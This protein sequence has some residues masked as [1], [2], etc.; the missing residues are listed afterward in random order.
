[1]NGLEL[2]VLIGAIILL[3]GWLAGRLRISAPLVLLGLG[4]ILGF[5][6]VLGDVELPPDLVLLLFLPALLYW[7]SLNTSAREIRRNLRVI[8][9]NAVPLVLVTA[10]V[11]ALIGH[12]FGLPWSV[13]IALGAVV[14]PTDATAVAAVVRHMPRRTL[15]ILRT[16]SLINDGTALAVYGVAV[17]AAVMERDIDFGE[18]TLRFLL[19]Y[20]GGI[21]IGLAVAALAIG[22]RRLVRGNSLLEN[23]VSLL[24]PFLAYLPAELLDVSGVVAV[25][26]AGLTLSRFGPRI[27]SAATRSQSTSFW[28][29]ATYILNGS[30]FVLVGF[31]LL[32]VI[33]DIDGDWQNAIALG[34]LVSLAVIVVR[35]AWSNTTPYVIRAL[36]RRPIQRTMRVSARQR[37]PS[38]WA[39]FRGAVSLAA[40]LALPETTAN[41]SP[42]PG[43]DLIIAATICVILVTL[44]VQGSTIAA[45]V[46]WA[47][48][49]TDPTEQEE[50]RLAQLAGIEA[51]AAAIPGE[52]ERLGIPQEVREILQREYAERLENVRSAQDDDPERVAQREATDHEGELRLAL[53]PHKREAIIRLRDEGKIDDVVLRRLQAHV[54]IEE[55]RLSPIRQEE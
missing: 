33:A 34:L 53:F 25:V 26:A 12:A 19:S 8:T 1:M 31:Q 24:T 16:E 46:R 10:G 13:A 14:A 40:A 11:V 17:A 48:L 32:A 38:A 54:D 35:L 52:A 39:G 9:L 36:D 2:V 51:A 29:L 7:E 21:L 50:E 27:V 47:Q 20:A 18:G 5:I 42:F 43:R 44:I 28:R 30:L 22:L 45:V 15:T 49:P 4:A 3:G 23:T 41:G 37:L 55:I 6:P